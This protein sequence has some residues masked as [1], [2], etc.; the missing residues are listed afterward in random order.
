VPD[1]SSEQMRDL[2]ARSWPGNVRELRNVAERF[3]LG[4]LTRVDEPTAGRGEGEAGQQGARRS[5]DEQLSGFE[6]YLIEEALRGSAGRAASASEQLGIPKKTL[7]D[8]MRRLGIST[9]EFK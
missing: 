8:K 2:M 3:A 9:E 7:Y 5:L 6:R 4:M 1:I